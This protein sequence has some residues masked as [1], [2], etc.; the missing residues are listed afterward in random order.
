MIRSPLI[1][2]HN[3]YNTFTQTAFSM[4]VY[5]KRAPPKAPKRR[6]R[7]GC[8]HCKE[9]KK[10]CNEVRPRCDRC[11][12]RNLECEYEAVK[13]RKR[14]RT[15]FA[16]SALSNR[17]TS[18]LCQSRWLEEE[19][20]DL[21]YLGNDVLAWDLS[22]PI[23]EFAE[24]GWDSGVGAI[25]E[26]LQAEALS[27]GTI[28]RSRSHYPDLAMIAPS[29][30]PS[31]LDEF[32]APLFMEFSEKRNRR[33]LVDHFCNVL[34]HL[35]VFKEDTGNPFRQLVLP[36][37]HA[38]SPV[39]DAIFAL[40]CAHLEYRG[41]QNAE[42]SL[43]FHNRAL[44]GLARLIEKEQSSRE[45]ILGAI[46][47]LVYYEVLVQRGNSSIVNGH[48][49]GA[50]TIMKSGPKVTSPA[51][52]FL[53]R[54]FRFYDVI[55]ALSLGTSPNTTSQPTATPFPSHLSHEFMLDSPLSSVDTLLGL[56]TDLWPIIHRLS[57]LL[58]FKNALES[59]M[60][61]GET[62]KA[63]VLRTELES[64]SQAIEL[65]LTSWKPQ[66][67]VNNEDDNASDPTADTRMQSILNNAEA[68]RHSAFVY[69]YRTIREFPRSYAPVQRHA[70]L[71][72]DA[73]SNVVVLAEK[74]HDGPMSALL[75]PL[76]VA[77]CEAVKA[78]DRQLATNAFLG[79]E[80]RQGMNNIARAWEIVQEVWRRMDEADGEVEVSWRKIC[81]EKGFSIV[82][83]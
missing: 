46:M 23:E 25:D 28:V 12:E 34:S 3:V 55:T 44:Q 41:V 22:S 61:A 54:A 45:E 66:L 13:P 11:I 8:I 58:S 27:S 67:P 4:L 51:G 79:T 47:L 81:E 74:C 77:S 5:A 49:K 80:K 20:N 75:W 53:E 40:S 36:L 42:K 71:S 63:T 68:Y 31:P 73:C 2:D 24:N 64:T 37:S 18:P 1:V 62:S 78:E 65:A 59:A 70:H 30:V 29:P 57:H 56:A 60:L 19:D 15:S 6:S 10:K 72:L 38:H 39:T 48:L 21:E 7:A 76:F 32:D 69:L 26:F 17:S 35:I 9:K 14:R 43:D 82:F 50:M 33:A 83:G 52:V 16:G